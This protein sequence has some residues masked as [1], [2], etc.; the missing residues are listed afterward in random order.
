VV[1]SGRYTRQLKLGDWWETDERKTEFLNHL[2]VLILNRTSDG[3]TRYDTGFDTTVILP[4]QN[5]ECAHVSP[6]FIPGVSNE[7]VL[8]TALYTPPHDLDGMP[9]QL[10]CARESIRKVEIDDSEH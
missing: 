7:P 4:P 3:I 10:R 8:Y 2:I 5:L 1:R 6:I 9:A